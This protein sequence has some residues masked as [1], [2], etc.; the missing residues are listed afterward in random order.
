MSEADKPLLPPPLVLLV[1]ILAVSMASILIRFAQ[2]E[3]SSL[4][5][6]AYRLS[7]ATLVVLPVA[8]GRY[9]HERK[10]LPCHDMLWMLLAG[11]FL[12]FHFAAWITSLEYTTV[13]SS[14]VL[15]SL[16][17]V[18]VA[19]VAPIFLRETITAR[20]GLGIAI[21]LIGS[22]LVG[23]SDT[24]AGLPPRCSLGGS[25]RMPLIG[26]ALALA[27]AVTVAGYFLIGRRVRGR[28]S[29]P[30]YIATVYG[31]A[32]VVCLLIV[33]ARG[34]PLVGY[35]PETYLWLTLVALVPQLIG[36]SSFNWAL[37]Y[38]PTAVVTVTTLGEPIGSTILAYL[39]LGEAPTVL[40]LVGGGFILF[41]ITLVAQER[42]GS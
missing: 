25:G 21:A 4:V 33:A 23:L 30:T 42:K 3:A 26:N 36:H 9:R 39:L 22:G 38:L 7:L 17:P 40:K 34:L 31:T 12:A 1:G 13:A 28:L 35:R 19:L 15:V 16:S 6:A 8:L 27:G 37:R 10:A 41:G 29:L 2:R 5:I 20:V 18:F 14:V 24:C 32:A 11:V